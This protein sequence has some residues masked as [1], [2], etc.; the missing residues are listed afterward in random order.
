MTNF[1]PIFPLGIV[2]YPGESVQ[3][4][5][6]EERYKQMIA[7][8]VQQQKSF[9]LPPVINGEVKE[10]GTLMEVSEVLKHHED[11]SFDIRVTGTEVFKILEIIRDVPDKLYH[12]AIVRYQE[13]VNTHGNLDMMREILK[14]LHTIFSRLNISKELSKPDEELVSYDIGHLVGM[15]LEDEYFLLELNR[16]IQR[17]EFIKRHLAKMIPAITGQPAKKSDRIK[18]GGHFKNIDGFSFS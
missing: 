3:L 11:G 7:E 8:C 13:N 16:E 1:I 2:V 17:Q 9:G 12:G 10:M 18:P 15:T 14:S 5:I 4:H 6:F